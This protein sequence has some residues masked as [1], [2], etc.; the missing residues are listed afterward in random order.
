M[1]IPYCA[2]PQPCR[3]TGR[4]YTW[5]PKSRSSSIMSTTGCCGCPGSFPE[6]HAQDK[7]RAPSTGCLCFIMSYYPACHVGAHGVVFSAAAEDDFGVVSHGLGLPG[8]VVGVYVMQWP[9]TRPP[10]R[11]SSTWFPHFEDVQVS[12]PILKMR[13]SSFT[14]AMLM[15]LGVSITLAASALYPR[16]G[17]H[18]PGRCFV[19]GVH[20]WAVSGVEPEV[21]FLWW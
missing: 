18:G 1:S 6:G 19:E 16:Q 12:I 8:E 7:H 5:Q 21:T 10:E 4:R 9:P 13:A 14:K 17:G 15:S 20:F 3:P 11:G 2:E